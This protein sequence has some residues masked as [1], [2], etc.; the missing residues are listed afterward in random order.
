MSAPH[1]QN[2][3]ISGEIPDDLRRFILTSV[4]SVPYLEA[5]L[6]LQRERGAGWTAPLLARRLYLPESR[7][8]ELLGHL[9]VGRHRRRSRP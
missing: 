2:D 5:I 4:P 6:L 1:D 7:A 9:H 3:M 8:V